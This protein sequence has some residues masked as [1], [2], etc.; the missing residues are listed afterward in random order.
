MAA[1]LL[2]SACGGKTNDSQ[3]GG[4]TNA[5][6][7]AARMHTV[8]AS[9][10]ADAGVGTHAGRDASTGR[11]AASSLDV[12]ASASSSTKEPSAADA[13]STQDA[14]VLTP[15]V[16]VI[17]AGEHVPVP[18]ASETTTTT[19]PLATTSA[20][21]TSPEPE[22]PSIDWSTLPAPDGC[23]VEPTFASNDDTCALDL[24]C[25]GVYRAHSR[26]DSGGCYCQNDALSWPMQ[27]EGDDFVD[28]CQ[29]A[30]DFC[31]PPTT[32]EVEGLQCIST[33]GSAESNTCGAAQNCS[34]VQEYASGARV[35][36]E[37]SESVEC[38]FD[39]NSPAGR[40][41]LWQCLCVRNGG[42]FATLAVPELSPTLDT[43][44]NAQQL[45]LRVQSMLPATGTE[46]EVTSESVGESYCYTSSACLI[47]GR[48]AGQTVYTSRTL[49]V[50]CN[51][52][53]EGELACTVDGP[54]GFSEHAIAQPSSMTEACRGLARDVVT[55]ID[56]LVP[57]DSPELDAG[58]GS[59]SDAGEAP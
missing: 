30:V 20:P 15:A 51:P 19:S 4:D 21:A 50:T 8:D 49:N 56:A 3:G 17:D 33:Y 23:G 13:Q 1:S 43:C 42:S 39:S 41:D 38:A 40:H 27:V 24:I 5:D 59:A 52:A 16:T 26:C 58:V 48:I 7:R 28:V 18:S 22:P 14:S 57:V 46:C 6:A 45:C 32:E 53:A 37:T 25:D 12:D 11:D 31:E 44:T 54:L 2:L 36:A 10:T 35:S 47:A 9:W 29:A 34:R 55:Q